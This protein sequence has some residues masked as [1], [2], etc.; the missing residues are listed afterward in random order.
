MCTNVRCYHRNFMKS[1]GCMLR[2]LI[3]ISPLFSWIQK[4]TV[5]SMG[6][7]NK[8][9]KWNLTAHITAVQY[10]V[11]LMNWCCLADINGH[12]TSSHVSCGVLHP[13]SSHPTLSHS[14]T[15]RSIGSNLADRYR[16]TVQNYRFASLHLETLFFFRLHF[17][18]HNVLNPQAIF[19]IWRKKWFSSR[20]L[21]TN[22]EPNRQ[23]FNWN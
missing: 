6:V 11:I 19:S 17:I 16:I 23:F 21:N 22:S 5:E 1:Y 18:H 20:N 8:K 15:Y 14:R 10:I 13:I 12:I 3:V 7:R 4:R 2:F 9:A